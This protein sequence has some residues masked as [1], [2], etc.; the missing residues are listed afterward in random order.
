MK[1]FRVE[2]Q[3]LL[4]IK[5]MVFHLKVFVNKI[6]PYSVESPFIKHVFIIKHFLIFFSFLN[7]IESFLCHWMC[8]L[9]DYKFFFECHK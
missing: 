7:Q 3:V 2:M 9:E 1:T 6:E 8:K 4:D 5:I